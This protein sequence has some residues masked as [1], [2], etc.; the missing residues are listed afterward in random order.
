MA[1]DLESNTADRTEVS[2]PDLSRPR[3]RTLEILNVLDGA[4]LLS[5]L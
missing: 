5:L 4:T 2:C 1:T 3:G